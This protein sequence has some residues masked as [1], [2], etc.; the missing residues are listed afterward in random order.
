MYWVNEERTLCL[1]LSRS[2]EL[3]SYTAKVV[4]RGCAM[5]ALEYFLFILLMVHAAAIKSYAVDMRR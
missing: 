1:I 5:C 2:Y 4:G 3:R